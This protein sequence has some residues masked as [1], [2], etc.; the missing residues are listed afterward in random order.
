MAILLHFLWVSR[1]LYNAECSKMGLSYLKTCSAHVT[2]GNPSK[3]RLKGVKFPPAS[4]R[5]ARACR[6]ALQAAPLA[7]R[8]CLEEGKRPP[9]SRFPC[10]M[11]RIFFFLF[12][13]SGEGKGESG[14]TGRGRG[15]VSVEL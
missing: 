1:P 6:V 8:N 10:W 15:L 4:S 2:D 11:F 7:E 14:A 3:H 5:W 12:V 9:S 13:C